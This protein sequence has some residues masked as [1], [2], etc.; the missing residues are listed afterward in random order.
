MEYAVLVYVLKIVELM[1]L[2]RFQDKPVVILTLVFVL[3]KLGVTETLIVL[4]IQMDPTVIRMVLVLGV[5]I[6]VK[7][8]VI[9]MEDLF[10]TNQ[11]VVVMVFVLTLMTVKPMLIVLLMP[12]L[13]LIVC[14]V[15]N[16][17]PAHHLQ[18]VEHKMVD[19]FH[20]NLL[21]TEELVFVKNSTVMSIRIVFLN[22]VI[23]P[24]IVNLI[25]P[26]GDVQVI[27]TVVL[28]MVVFLLNNHIVI[29]FLVFVPVHVLKMPIVM[30][31]VDHSALFRNPVV[32]SVLKT[33]IALTLNG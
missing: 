15:G 19:L 14:L 26:A 30:I 12:M 27:M 32:L 23:L 4:V 28:L 21:V 24:L 9:L 2:E 8:V 3:N 10:R 5:L 13:V 33:S 20:V 29:V 25:E 22:L 18:C 1:M 31:L 6:L 17:F 7:H 11:Y 16:V